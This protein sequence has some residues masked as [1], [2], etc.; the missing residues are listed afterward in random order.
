MGG[1]RRMV[2]FIS[3]RQHVVRFRRGID[4]VSIDV[5]NV[6]ALLV[7]NMLVCRLGLRVALSVVWCSVI[8]VWCSIIVVW[9]SGIVV[10]VMAVGQRG[11]SR[12]RA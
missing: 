10:C 5:T 7:Q 8:V 2:R 11:K 1:L 9:S 6:A 4:N 12:R 3:R